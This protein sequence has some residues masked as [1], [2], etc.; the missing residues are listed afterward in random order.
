MT[1]SDWRERA[2]CRG[3]GPRIFFPRTFESAAPAKA[4]CATCPVTAQCLRFCR[5]E[6]GGLEK[7]TGIWGGLTEK[8][9]RPTGRRT[10]GIRERTC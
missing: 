10:Y 9:R 1:D 2:A 6:L 8:E 5:K 3:M 7:R 4:V